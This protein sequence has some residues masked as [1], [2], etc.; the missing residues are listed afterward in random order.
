MTDG[1]SQS[2]AMEDTGSSGSAS[3]RITFSTFNI[4][5]IMGEER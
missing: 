4:G 5:M 2:I 3:H 1:C